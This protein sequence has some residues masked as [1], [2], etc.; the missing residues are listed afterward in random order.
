MNLDTYHPKIGGL[1]IMAA[2][3]QTQ[4]II[5][6]ANLLERRRLEYARGR[7]MARYLSMLIAQSDK[8]DAVQSKMSKAIHS[9]QKNPPSFHSLSVHRVYRDIIIIIIIS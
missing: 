9:S 8:I 7:V 1:V 5:E 4:E 6:R 3:T 2:A